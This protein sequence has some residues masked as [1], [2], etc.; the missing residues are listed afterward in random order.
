[1]PF[2]PRGGSG[3]GGG[4]GGIGGRTSDLKAT[5]TAT[6]TATVT[7]TVSEEPL[8][9]AALADIASIAQATTWS[10][11]LSGLTTGEI[12][13]IG[14]FTIET[15]ALRDAVIIATAGHYELS[16]TITGLASTSSAGTSRGVML[17][18]FVRD[19]GG[20]DTVLSPQGTPSYSRN[21]YGT[22]SEQHGSH[23]DA[24]EA[25]EAGDKIRVQ[26]LYQ[27]QSD[28]PTLAIVGATSNFTIKGEDSPTVT[29]TADVD[30][31]VAVSVA[32][33]VGTIIDVSGE[34]IEPPDADDQGS[35][36]LDTYKHDVSFAVR[37]F[38][39]TT[40][41]LGTGTALTT[42]NFISNTRPP[43][44][45]AADQMWYKPSNGHYHISDADGI[46]FN[47]DFDFDTTLAA[48]GLPGTGY[49]D[50]VDIGQYDT[51][52]EAANA[53]PAARLCGDD[54][55]RLLQPRHN[56]R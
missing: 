17:A 31:D 14:G 27:T 12:L 44:A 45:T 42:V 51:A 41:A 7:P 40:L 47:T 5:A 11:V 30:I 37:K 28:N 23:V 16:T 34:N 1:M 55:I 29:A 43:P 49:T 3:G 2:S 38:R 21:Q 48:L 35:V 56:R 19:R 24:V 22:F 20:V 9:S 6:G 13:N 26:V 39:A 10:N 15:V 8:F 46:W 54:A 18:R 25:F 4:G 50:A 53:I 36:W 32:G 33:L 52:G